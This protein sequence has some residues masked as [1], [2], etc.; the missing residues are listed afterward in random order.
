MPTF[1]SDGICDDGGPGAEYPDCQYGTDCSDCG[2]RYVGLPPPSPPL[3][4]PPPP[5]PSPPPSQPPPPS[6]PPPSPSPSPSPPSPP[7]PPTP[8]PSLLALGGSHTCA[9]VTNSALLKCWGRNDNGQLGDGTTTQRATPTTIDVGGAVGLLAL[10]GSCTCAYVTSSALLK[11]WGYNGNG[12]LGDGTT[13]PRA[14]PTTINVGGAVGL[15]AFG[16]PHTC[17]YLTNSTLLKCWGSN[18][19]GQLGDG[20]TTQ[21]ATPTTMD[22]GGAV[23]LLA[24]GYS[25]TCAY[26]T[27]SA[28][29]KCWGY[30]YNGQLGD[31][32]T[33]HRATPTTIDVGGAVGLLALGDHHTCAY[34]TNSTLLK[35]WGYNIYGQLGDGTTTQRATPT[36][37][38]VGGAVG[39]LALGGSHTCA[40][41]TN[42]TLLKCWGANYFG[43]LGD[44]TTTQRATPTTINFWGT[45]G[46][47]ALGGSHT[48]AYVTN[49]TLP[50][51][52]G[53]N[54]YGQLGD[55]TTTNRVSPFSPPA[56]CGT[57]SADTFL[58]AGGQVYVLTCQV[59]VPSG[60]VL[61]IAQG[62][63]I[64]ASPVAAGGG[65]APAL[66]VEKGGSLLAEGSATAPITFTA[67]NPTESSSSSSVSTDPT[68][69]ETRGKWGGLI[70]LG[71]APT[72]VATTTI[73]EGITARTYGGSNP[74]DSS[75]SL[76]YVRVWHGGAV[77]GAN[78]EINGITFGGVGSGTIVDHCEVAY[79]VDDGFEFFGGTVNVKYLSALFVGD[80]G[81]DTDQGYIGK[82]QFLF[83][84]EGLSGDHS[85]EIDSGVGS[86]Q[87]ATPRSHPAFYSFTLIGGGTGTG[88]R[89][90]ELMH[91]NDGTG[92][93]FGNGILAYPHLNG[94]LF[95]DCGSTLSY[96]QTLPAAS[97]SISNPGYLYF[98]ANNIIDTA[99]SASQVALHTGT[100]AACTP[101][102]TWTAVMGAP[103]FAAVA[104]T[105][106]AGGSAT[107]NPLPLAS[108][109]ACTGTKDAAPN[110]DPFFSSVSCKGAFGSSTDNWLA[111]Y[112]WLACSGKMVGSTC[113]SS[114][115][116]AALAPPFV[117]L[118]PNVALVS[119]HYSSNTA[120][121]ANISY[122][123]ASQVFVQSGVTLT[124]PAGTTIFAL[125][126]PNGVAAPAL[127]VVK[128]GMLLAAGTASSPITL[129]TI[130]SESALS[131]SATAVTDSSS[132]VFALGARG[133]WG[134]L[135]L[136]GNAPTN[137]PTTTQIEGITGYTYGGTVV[138]ES[139]GSLQ[140]VRVWHG[141]A[142]VGANNEINGITFA[143][144][145]SGTTVAYCEVAYNADDGFEFFGGTVNVKYLSVLF[146]GDDAFDTDDGYVGKGQFLFALLG[147]VGNHGAEMDSRYGSTPRSHPAFYGMTLVGAGALSTRPGNAM[148]RLR[149]G[150]GGKFG[151]LILANVAT[152]PGIRIDTCSS[153]GST[154]PSIVSVL[155]AASVSLD[156]YLF[157]S[158]NNIIQ[159]PTAGFQ[160][161]S[162][163]TGTVPAFVNTDPLI[164]GGTFTETSMVP[165][166]PR[167]ACGSAAYS[168]VDPVPNGDSFFS[169]TTYKGAFGSV[170]WLDG[171]SL[172]NLPN[173][174][175]FVSGSF[176]CP[177]S[178][179]MVE[180]ALC[181]TLSEDTF[182]FA[183]GQVYVLTCQVFVPSGIVL[184][185]AQGVT[186]YAS[187]VAAGGGGAPALIVEKGGSLLAEG[188]ATA[189][190][191]FTAFNPT[192]SSSSSSVSTD[193]TVLETRGKWG[194]LILLGSAPTNVATTTIIE[195][196]TARTYGGSNPTDSSGSL[197]YVR[198]WH[199]GAVVGANNE[200]N[201]IT[202][203][204]VGSGTIVDHC[205]VAYNVDDGF[206]FFGG[207]VNVK[208][209]SVLFMGD[210]GFDTDQGYIGKGQFLFVIE[211]LTGDHS[212]EI[213]SGIGSNQD[214]TPRSHP[215][216]YSFTLIGGGTGTGARTGELMHVNDGTGGKFGNGILAHPHLNGLLFE[217][218]GSTLSYTQ[219]LP[220][221]SVSI[222]NPGYLYFSANNIIDTAT[223]ASQFALHTGTTAACTPADTWTA[224]LGAPGF[225]AVATTDL[226]GGSA[227]FNPLPLA[228]GL[229]CTGTKDAPPN[230][231]SF[232]SSV[233]C[234]GAFGSS[235]D[236][237][238]A[239]YSW[240]ACSG[241]MAGSTCTSSAA[242]AALTPPFATL[243]PNVAL[244]SSNYSSNTALGA[245]IS[246]ILASQVFV[247]SGVMLTIPA[248]TTIF[249]LPVPNGVAAPAIV[250]VKG[251]MLLA[252]GTASS[253]ITLT[254]ILSESA[255]SGSAIAVANSSS[256]VFALG[257]R[258]K[259]GGLILLGNA[260]TNMPTTT[261][262]EG[263][264]GYT[265]GG[266]VATESSG[267][268]QYVRV[269]HGG[270]VVGANNEINGIT[271][272][273][274]GSGTVVD[275]CEVAFNL[276][277]GFEFFG[278]T[279]NV[280]YLSVL[281]M[282][283]DGFDTDQGYVG[284]GQFLFVIE[285]LTGDHSMEIDSGI[286]SNQD[287]TPRSHPAFYSFTL[288]G[289]GTGTGA[290]TGE[291][292]HVNDGTGGKFGNGILAHPHLNG[293]LFEDCGSTLSYTQ[294]LPAASVSISNPG[295]FYFSANNI[296]DT[297]TTASQFALHTGTTAACTAADTW[298]AVSGS[299]GFVAVATTDL[300]E[301]SATFNPLPSA[302]GLACTGTK[303]AAPNGDP[304]FSSVSCKGAFG[305]ST[306][307]W[308]AGYSWLACSGK[309]VGSTCTSSAAR[310][311]PP[312]PSPPPR[313]PPS[314]P[315]AP[316]PMTSGPAMTCGPGTYSNSITQQCE[317]ACGPSNG[318]RMDTEV[319]LDTTVDMQ[320]LGDRLRD[321]TSYLVEH[322]EVAAS[323][324]DEDFASIK[325]EE[326]RSRLKQLFGQ[327]ALA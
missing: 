246:Y 234:K 66:I 265:Y 70:L 303:D 27:A 209:L 139:S 129:T 232:F 117:T 181:G 74:T 240:L 273:G 138:T 17:A 182:L 227:T 19:A 184:R 120:L 252:A 141:G 198:V 29:L 20:T 85:M 258:G 196:I 281:F 92:G 164:A 248:G 154:A 280:K 323:I 137:M 326:L 186:I 194:G 88:A 305:S 161:V 282:G 319:P 238:L 31:G 75:G 278:G 284:K 245:N 144:V 192:E 300:A 136:L 155:P 287:V 122:I 33:T 84:I 321:V 222:S 187:P 146:A 7:P 211:G 21:R 272:G 324:K 24:L 267:L 4:P 97:V 310:A 202:F 322:P 325:D 124:I 212:M 13:T 247:Q 304:F 37:I 109:L 3:S 311:A 91:V 292:I 64:Y 162:P 78:N 237:W 60:V 217:D 106:L 2:L 261:I 133:K 63:T 228:S 130:L 318:R 286:G 309:M 291:L 5:P 35:C 174:P 73:I 317:I 314:P 251:G 10:G 42:S 301:G 134:G 177:T 156:T 179:A 55:N 241:K 99:T 283:D 167:P 165:I 188:S 175:G 48:C 204:G 61:R 230:G 143:G 11:C 151:N 226:A 233:S 235:T 210:D 36:T 116:R 49:S 16:G 89:A 18:W 101:A 87:D 110:G 72:N 53:Y 243:L 118:L 308:L 289:G 119:S 185:I 62:V 147:A 220:A 288:I 125:P 81:F 306:D 114:A 236:N 1:A 131:G 195:G 132:D 219:T 249:A 166:D 12:Q 46:L 259:W 69:L 216:F 316:P 208:Y 293:L 127:V 115:A 39:L 82:G 250:V 128:G 22:V 225:V 191:T 108:G 327:P 40:Y 104:T 95:E 150:T 279:V 320:I 65:G 201:G 224:V 57:L 263:I 23:G 148:M 102:D 50:K 213:D 157:F 41:V 58:V 294:T 32:T 262:I 38:D 135:I 28:L 98:S 8:S 158:S 34:L 275:H 269:W 26:L 193:P 299:P 176:T 290:R 56:L 315:P 47:L 9:Y 170:N 244:V 256:D 257:A 307:N 260:P 276:D 105:D 215:A 264:T 68:V 297:A 239:G 160:I 218:C 86:N 199:G 313:P 90:G 302:S 79:N 231:D 145:G 214:A 83:V 206:E 207:T 271:F 173:R 255:L 295:Y 112:S 113:T 93:K 94:L 30:N 152:H 14:T 270:A 171:W 268:L 103:G 274:V 77:V 190:I 54:Y 123:L 59:F 71:S 52:W 15:L 312:P 180:V 242:R 67:F 51:C 80:D 43:Q 6:P 197:Q 172:F 100:T 221:A 111:G 178:A 169:T 203:G 183:G 163:C 45:V 25:H 121:G 153:G 126:V 205:E 266:T 223:S 298:T 229:A 277:D 168:N 200:I 76:Q 254:T 140:Y 142:I 96:T 159:S 285:G 189:P 107:F 253:P 149:E 44:G 296:I